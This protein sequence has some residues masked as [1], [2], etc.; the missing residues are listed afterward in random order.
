L[1]IIAEAER[2]LGLMAPTW[3]QINSM[4]DSSQGMFG[5]SVQRRYR[6]TVQR[7]PDNVITF[8]VQRDQAAGD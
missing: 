8:P 3:G 1:P 6:E 2:L 7:M 5:Q 4:L